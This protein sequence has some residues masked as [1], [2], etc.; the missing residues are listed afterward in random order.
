MTI[1][2]NNMEAV[3]TKSRHSKREKPSETKKDSKVA[4]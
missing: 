1:N 4:E 2:R 3:E